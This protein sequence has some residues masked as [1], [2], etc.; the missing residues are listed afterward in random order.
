MM[1]GLTDVPVSTFFQIAAESCTPGHSIKLVKS[2]C[3]TD[4]RLYLLPAALRAPQI[5]RYLVYSEADFEVFRPTGATR[6]TDGGEI[7]HGPLL[8]AKFGGVRISPAAGAAKHVELLP[9]ALRAPQICRYL[10]YSEVDFEVFGP[11]GDTL[12]RWG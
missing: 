12:H 11:R 5:C 2:H 7:W 6:C 9:A 4:L 10:V 8:R 3:H 1:H